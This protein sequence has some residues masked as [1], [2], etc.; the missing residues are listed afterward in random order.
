MA[1][2]GGRSRLGVI[3]SSWLS[4]LDSARNSSVSASVRFFDDFRLLGELSSASLSLLL[5]LG[6]ARESIEAFCFGR[7][8]GCFFDLCFLAFSVIAGAEGGC[9]SIDR[10]STVLTAAG[11]RNRVLSAKISSSSSSSLLSAP[12]SRFT[13]C[14]SRFIFAGR[15]RLSKPDS[16]GPRSSSSES[17]SSKVVVAFRIELSGSDGPRASSELETFSV[18]LLRDAFSKD[19]VAVVGRSGCWTVVSFIGSSYLK[20]VKGER[21]TNATRLSFDLLVGHHQAPVAI[22]DTLALT[23]SHPCVVMQK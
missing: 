23:L 1:R 3:D 8:G 17:E 13:P 18:L 15:L 7:F 11:V 19:S 16:I 22:Y 14:I 12:L 4:S 9:L 21:A 6:S 2:L 5:L 10:T 20:S